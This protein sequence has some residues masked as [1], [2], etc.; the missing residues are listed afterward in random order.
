[1][2]ENLEN[3]KMFAVTAAAFHETLYVWGD[4][5]GNGISVDKSGGDLV[6]KQYV[7]GGHSGYVELFR[8][9]DA[10]VKQI[11]AYGYDGNDTITIG[12]AVTDPATVMGGKGGDYL[13][14]GGGESK[15]YGHG[16]W[17]G[18]PH[19]G[20]ATDD[21][22]ADMLVSGKGY[23]MQYGQKGNDKHYTDTNATSGYDAMFGGDGNDEFH[24]SGHGN[25]AYAFGDAGNDVFKPAQGATQRSSFYGG[26]GWDS[27]SYRNWTAAV[28]VRPDNATLSG[29]RYG[30]RLHYLQSD[31]EFIEGSE[32]GDLFSG[33]E[34][35]NT[36]Y[37]WGGND[38]MYGNGG[39]DVL[40]GQAGHDTIHGNNGNDYLVG[41]EGNDVIH[42]ND[43][44]DSVYG[45]QGSD[46]IHG[47][48]GNDLL[49]GQEDPDWIYGDAGSDTLVGG[50]GSDYLHAHDGIFGND[51]IYGDNQDGTGG[52]G[53]F[54]VA[55]ID[56]M[57]FLKDTTTGAESVT[58]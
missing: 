54:D 57:L 14:G 6:V 34:T 9:S 23:A 55:Y 7:G 31:V 24:V 42:G 21:A 3:R 1:M 58:A 43:G 35:N 8:A 50:T 19:H 20:P 10:Y 51:R 46:D 38:L 32:F 11:R 12:D 56:K 28:Y 40:L 30:T 25:H 16:D 2:F 17:A 48:N 33:S 22:A 39:N 47:G 15:L 18:D 5:S 45:N 29:L 37:G 44:H 52:F 4:A 27:T 13:K 49:H 36:F 26:G 41:N 53:S